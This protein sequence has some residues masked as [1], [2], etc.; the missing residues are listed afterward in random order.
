MSFAYLVISQLCHLH[1]FL[2]VLNVISQVAKLAQQLTTLEH[3][4]K[5]QASK[6][7]QLDEAWTK[8]MESLKG[9]FGE[10]FQRGP[11]LKKKMAVSTSGGKVG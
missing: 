10:E 11:G 9:L 6:Q 3:I 7:T 2:L 4:N 5:E 1:T 8:H